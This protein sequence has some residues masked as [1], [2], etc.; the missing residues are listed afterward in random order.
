MIPEQEGVP[1]NATTEFNQRLDLIRH[2]IRNSDRILLVRGDSGLGKSTLLAYLQRLA[3]QEWSICRIDATP[4]LQPDALLHQLAERF[5]IRPA[6]D[7]LFGALVRRMDDLHQ[8]GRLPLILVDDAHS[9]PVPSLIL[10][11]RIHE[12]L[13]Q[14]ALPLR[15]VLFARPEIDDLLNSPQLQAME[16]GTIQR[17]ELTPLDLRQT[18]RFVRQILQAEGGGAAMPSAA[19]L[20]RLHRESGG[21]PGEVE[22]L[23]RQLVAGAG[24]GPSPAGTPSPRTIAGL[25]RPAAAA[26][27]VVALV[28]L[29]VLVFQERINAIFQGGE[30]TAQPTAE[31]GR[32]MPLPLP[33]R[34]AADTAE[35][36]P[37]P[38]PEGA[39]P[40]K[41]APQPAAT[42]AE[43]SEPFVDSRGPSAPAVT[44]PELAAPATT[45]ETGDG[46]GPGPDIAAESEV[47]P[48][49]SPVMEP[50]ANGEPQGPAPKE[51]PPA[52]APVRTPPAEQGPESA[53]QAAAAEV[54]VAPPPEEAR[55]TVS[56][57]PEPAEI[58]TAPRPAVPEKAPAPVRDL[59]SAGASATGPE[60]AAPAP[61]APPTPAPVEERRPTPTVP[62]PKPAV[63]GVRDEAWLLKRPPGH[64]TLQ[65]VGVQD[66]KAAR[67]FI[68]RHRLS[69]PVAYFRTSRDGKPWYPV[70]Y[71]DYPSREK[72]VAA[73]D[74][75]PGR[76]ARSGAWPRTFA[77]VQEAIRK[78]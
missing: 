45:S 69:G 55:P 28:L 10:L 48:E 74:R 29:L 75:L 53:S 3:D 1:F 34:E 21:A 31:G 20:A 49:P 16:S 58:A 38:L 54:Q 72:A 63:A 40:G 5:D 7:D 36:P 68:R 70:V 46:G 41:T 33:R 27:A 18:E 15:L 73:R 23:T 32:L 60:P 2:L 26:I 56:P 43:P 35:A 13:G 22:R 67:A 59:S 30:E 25:S 51:P 65:L 17:I 6:G 57:S 11:F 61:Q 50:V 47:T 12:H 44:P 71:G 42:E 4:M 24:G 39:P 62:A 9:L 37:P 52:V 19:R 14:G 64:Y 8:G 77:S 66:Q 76:L 78:R